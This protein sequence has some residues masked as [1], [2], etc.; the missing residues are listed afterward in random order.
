MYK[1]KI[2]SVGKTKEPWLQAALQEYEERLRSSLSFEWILA[3]TSEQL[4]QFLEKEEKFLCLDPFA[5]QFSSEE[6]S[7]FLLKSLEA[8]GSR[9]AFVIGGAEGLP[10]ELKNRAQSLLSLSKMTFTHQ[11]TRLILAE[12]IYRA[13]EIA[14]GS[15]YH[16]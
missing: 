7:S 8:G 5:K 3:K 14:K 4:K 16:K 12:Q 6:F 13:L 15:G 9:L 11:V 1:I 2:Y 10:P